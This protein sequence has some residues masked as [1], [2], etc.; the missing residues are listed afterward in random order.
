MSLVK[1]D[2]DSHVFL[3]EELI[4]FFGDLMNS[5]FSQVSKETQ[6]F[7]NLSLQSI[8]M[9]DHQCDPWRD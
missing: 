1:N 2:L 8:L 5:L 6:S 3:D 7:L 9:H 4:A